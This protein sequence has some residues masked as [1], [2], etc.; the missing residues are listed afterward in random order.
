MIFS[1]TSFLP[2]NDFKISSLKTIISL[3]A[4]SRSINQNFK[5]EFF[6][7]SAVLDNTYNQIYNFHYLGIDLFLS[8]VFLYIVFNKFQLIEIEY[9][10]KIKT[11]VTYKRNQQI[12]K[13]FFILFTYI[14]IRN[15]ESAT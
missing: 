7:I 10:E 9:S 5:T 3:R 4:F 8:I 13:L 14:F 6:S 1:I 11:I 12:A 15:V 2:K